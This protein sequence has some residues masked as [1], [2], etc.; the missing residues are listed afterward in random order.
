[1]SDSSSDSDS[2]L[3]SFIDRVRE[4][5]E[6]AYNKRM[7]EGTVSFPCDENGYVLPLFSI[8]GVNKSPESLMR[9]RKRLLNNLHQAEDAVYNRETQFLTSLAGI[10]NGITCFEPSPEQSTSRGRT[11]QLRGQ[12]EFHV[13][14]AKRLFSWS[15]FRY[16]K[17]VENAMIAAGLD[18]DTAAPVA[19]E[20]KTPK[21]KASERGNIR[22]KGYYLRARRVK[23]SK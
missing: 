12:K 1:M 4:A 2:K 8:D 10:R 18:K 20:K 6:N 11:Q 19:D 14:D 3:G 5:A 17:H 22:Q 7:R 23:K 15:S 16:Q 9:R 21:T 13:D